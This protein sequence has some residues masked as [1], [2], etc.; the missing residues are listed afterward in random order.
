MNLDGT[1]HHWVAS[2]ANFNFVI[3]YKSGKVNVDVD[4]LSHIPSEDN[5]QHI[6]ADTVQVIILNVIQGTALVEVY[7]CSRQVIKI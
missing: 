2:L 7:S 6:N 5:D 3:N 1:G 4:V